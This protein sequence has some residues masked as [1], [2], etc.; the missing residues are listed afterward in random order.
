MQL[1]LDALTVIFEVL[2]GL[3]YALEEVHHVSEPNVDLQF[4]DV[5]EYFS[6]FYLTVDVQADLWS[7][8]AEPLFVHY[9]HF[10]RGF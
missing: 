10:G 1:V 4:I 3:I 8:E 5:F 6:S 9:H 2:S 7:V